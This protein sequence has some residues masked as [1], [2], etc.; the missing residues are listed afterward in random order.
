MLN[1]I[2]DREICKVD[3]DKIMTFEIEYMNELVLVKKL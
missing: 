1:E 2:V 3:Y